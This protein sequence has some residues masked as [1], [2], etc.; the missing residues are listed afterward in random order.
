MA[1]ARHIRNVAGGDTDE[2]G[3]KRAPLSREQKRRMLLECAFRCLLAAQHRDKSPYPV[4]NRELQRWVRLAARSMHEA[5]EHT[6]AAQLHAMVHNYKEART[7]LQAQGEFKL[8][9]DVCLKASKRYAFLAAQSEVRV[10]QSH[11]SAA[12]TAGLYCDL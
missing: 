12:S 3:A 1:A 7:M 10:Q 9:A 4:S 2:D 11:C 5:Q 8:L 6:A